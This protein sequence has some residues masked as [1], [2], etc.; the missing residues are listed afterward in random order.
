MWLISWGNT[1]ELQDG[2]GPAWEAGRSAFQSRLSPG[3]HEAQ[4]DC[5]PAG[6]LQGVCVCPLTR[7]PLI[8]TTEIRPL[9]SSLPNP[10]LLSSSSNSASDIALCFHSTQIS[11]PSHVPELEHVQNWQELFLSHP[12]TSSLYIMDVSL[13]PHHTKRADPIWFNY[14]RSSVNSRE[15]LPSPVVYEENT[16][17]DRKLQGEK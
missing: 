3:H 1:Q 13:F 9:L 8:P 17:N 16:T 15:L 5:S 4:T 7:A 6:T 10:T 14:C 12:P 2:A 11:L